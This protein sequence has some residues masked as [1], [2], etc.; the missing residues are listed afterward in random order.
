MIHQAKMTNLPDRASRMTRLVSLYFIS[1]LNS[2]LLDFGSKS[3][4][5]LPVLPLDIVMFEALSQAC[6]HSNVG[7]TPVRVA[8]D[9]VYDWLG[10][11]SL[12]RKRLIEGAKLEGILGKPVHGV[13]LW[14]HLKQPG[15]HNATITRSSFLF[16]FALII[17]CD[18]YI[19]NTNDCG[20]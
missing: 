6:L 13:L 19:H 12:Q 3:K 10:G 8:A 9:A 5:A 17:L 4:S 20:I 11:L 1:L 14:R 18:L 2:H 7:R 16:C 15:S